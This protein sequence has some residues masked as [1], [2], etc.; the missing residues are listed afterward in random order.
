MSNSSAGAPAG[1]VSVATPA[2]SC[3]G[4]P[5]VGTGCPAVDAATVVIALW[6]AEDHRGKPAESRLLLLAAVAPGPRSRS[7]RRAGADRVRRRRVS[8]RHLVTLPSGRRHAHVT[9]PAATWCNGN[10]RVP[11]GL[12]GAR[13]LVSATA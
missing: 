5:P 12:H 4:S 13:E 2:G 9:R 11:V 6:D 1:A 3:A 8:G 10:G 7:I